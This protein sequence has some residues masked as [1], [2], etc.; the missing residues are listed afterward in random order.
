M[1]QKW[2]APKN[3]SQLTTPAFLTRLSVAG[4]WRSVYKKQEVKQWGCG[5]TQTKRTKGAI[6]QLCTR[7]TIHITHIAQGRP[8]RGQ[9]FFDNQ[10]QVRIG[11]VFRFVW[12]DRR[13]T[14][15][16]ILT[17]Q[18]YSKFFSAE[19]YFSPCEIVY[20]LCLSCAAAM[21]DKTSNF[22]QAILYL[23][24]LHHISL[25]SHLTSTDI[26][27]PTQHSSKKKYI[28]FLFFGPE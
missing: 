13:T 6:D 15:P 9:D 3:K 17:V 23:I 11:V 8:I 5:W 1:L 4:L 24:V 12:P 21:L 16:K 14:P 18:E 25:L 19:F 10:S 28:C 27:V 20:Y 26:T 22:R 2:Y 7:T